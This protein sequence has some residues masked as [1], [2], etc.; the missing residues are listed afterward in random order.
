MPPARVYLASASPRRRELLRQ[1]GVAYR[2]LS[3]AVDETPRPGEPPADY[4]ARLAL[5]KARAGMAETRRR[6]AAWPVLGADTSVVVDGAIL[7]KPRDRAEGLAMLA[8]LSGREHA[9]L[10]AVALATASRQAVK[11]QESQVR[12][13]ELS[14]AER[15]AY[16][17]SGEP[18][19]KAGGYGIQGRAAAF[20]AELRGSYSGVM[21]LPLFETA[22]LLREFGLPLWSTSTF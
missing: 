15:A 1:I 22:E 8:L 18:A 6:R 9:V 2:L 21:G 19:D 10:S 16:W 4:V 7:G 14:P 3:V 17:D 11:V 20:V 13:R 12:F 5:A